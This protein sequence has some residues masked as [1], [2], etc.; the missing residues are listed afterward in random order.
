MICLEMY[1]ECLVG[2]MSFSCLGL[3][4]L[5]W[6]F[7]CRERWGF[8]WLD[9]LASF[10]ALI[11]FPCHIYPPSNCRRIKVISCHLCFFLVQLSRVRNWIR[12]CINTLYCTM[13]NGIMLSCLCNF[14]FFCNCYLM[15]MQIRQSPINSSRQCKPVRSLMYAPKYHAKPP[16]FPTMHPE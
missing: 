15:I 2:F 12:L 13:L 9:Y 3:G 1:D 11:V 5:A 14:C 6:V 8:G 7:G 4:V 10:L 16:A